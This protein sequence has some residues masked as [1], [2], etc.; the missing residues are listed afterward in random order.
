MII[1]TYGIIFLGVSGTQQVRCLL[2]GSIPRLLKTKEAPASNQLGL[3]VIKKQPGSPLSVYFAL[4]APCFKK[5]ATGSPPEQKTLPRQVRIPSLTEN[6]AAQLFT[7]LYLEQK[8]LFK[9]VPFLKKRHRSLI[10]LCITI[11]F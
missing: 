9:K 5:I 2:R 11:S 6:V 8:T 1:I 4:K 3:S 7:S 10:Q